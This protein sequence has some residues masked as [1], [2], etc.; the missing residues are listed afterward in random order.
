MSLIIFHRSHTK[1]GNSANLANKT[2]A[3]SK[4]PKISSPTPPAGFEVIAPPLP[5]ASSNQQ[6]KPERPDGLSEF[7]YQVKEVEK[8][9]RVTLEAKYLGLIPVKET[10]RI[11]QQPWSM[12][13]VFYQPSTGKIEVVNSTAFN[14]TRSHVE[15][16]AQNFI[17][18]MV[19]TDTE[20]L[21]YLRGRIPNIQGFKN[22]IVNDEQDSAA[23]FRHYSS[24]VK[25]FIEDI[26]ERR[27]KLG[28]VDLYKQ[29]GYLEA[30]VDVLTEIILSAGIVRDKNLLKFLEASRKFAIQ[31]NV[32]L[33]KL[34]ERLK[35]KQLV[36]GVDSSY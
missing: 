16:S 21:L 14:P 35:Y 7:K 19:V 18:K 8:S 34:Q 12:F 24:K 33:D 6:T 11:P 1:R 5:E 36:R 29:I 17:A 22:I 32:T 30:Q 4:A 9:V 3:P 28:A 10:F 31:K 27:K 26:N 25:R 15:N 23:A 20:T 2:D 13:N